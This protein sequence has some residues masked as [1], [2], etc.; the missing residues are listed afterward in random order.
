M[1]LLQHEAFNDLFRTFK[2]TACHLEVQDPTPT[3]ASEPFRCSRRKAGPTTNGFREWEE[4]VPTYRLWST[5]EARRVVTEPHRYVDGPCG[6]HRNIEDGEDIRY[7]P[8][9][10]IDR[11]AV[12]GYFW[13]F[14]DTWSCSNPLPPEV[15]RW[16]RSYDRSSDSRLFRSV[17]NRVWD[18][19]SHRGVH[20]G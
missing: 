1:Q 14:D 16:R 12:G 9:H 6:R 17:W 15:L 13:L 10:Q 4:L 8:R 19:L 18:K 11:R 2:H 3:E 5:D 7:L 20:P